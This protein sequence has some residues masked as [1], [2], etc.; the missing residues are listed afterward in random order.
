LLPATTQRLLLLAAA[1]P[2]GDPALLWR[3][4]GSIGISA[5][6]VSPAEADGLLTVGDR[7]T[8]RHPLVR[9]AVYQAAPTVDRRQAHRVIA[10]VTDP[11][12][13]PDRRA[14][15]RLRQQPGPMRTSPPSLSDRPTGRRRAAGLGSGCVP[16]A[17]DRADP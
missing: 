6:A 7:V 13:D 16:G 9:S 10:E 1:E 14:W 11:R 15:H 12:I 4:A 3:A 17:G 2:T 5:D 8:F